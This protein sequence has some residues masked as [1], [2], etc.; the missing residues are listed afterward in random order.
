MPGKKN[1]ARAF[2][3]ATLVVLIFLSGSLHAQQTATVVG[4]VRD[5]SGAVVP[6]TT[7]S[8][9]NV[10][11]GLVRK[12]EADTQGNYVL[13]ALPIGRYTF[14]AS[15]KGFKPTQVPNVTL[16]VAQEARIDV[17][18]EPGDVSSSVTVSDAPSLLV[19]DSSSIGQV[20]ENKKIIDLPLNGRD[21]T[22]LASLT[23]GA[24]TSNIATGSSGEQHGF[25]TVQVSGGQSSKTEFLLDGITDQEQLYDG[26]QFS[27]SIDFLQEFRVQ[28]NAFSAEFGRGSAVI[29]VSTKGGTN[30]YHGTI[31]E[32]LRND[33]LD[34][35]NFFALSNPPLRRNQFG[36]S[37]GGPIVHN[38]LFF[39]LNY[40]GTQLREPTTRNTTVPLAALRNGDLSVLSKTVIDPITQSPF[41]GNVIPSNRID[42]TSA[43]FLN[44]IP[45]PNTANGTYIWNASTAQ[46][47]NQGNARV[48]YQLSPN[49]SLFARYSINDA[50]NTNPGSLPV[51]G[52]TAQ[53][54][55]VQN[56]VIS[57]T[58]LFNP[59]LLNEARIG[60]A[61]LYYI[62]APQ[63]LGTNYTV[64]SGILGFTEESQNFP[65]FPNLSVS[66]YGALVNGVPFAPIRNPTNTWQYNDILT[67]TAGRHT[68]KMG[69][70]FR[71][72]HLTSTNAAYSRGSFSYNGSFSGNSFVDYLLGFPSSGT[73]DFPRNHFGLRDANY[74]LFIQDDFKVTSRLTLNLGLRYE[75]DA[76][77][78][79]DLGQ[80]SYFDMTR[81]KWIVSTYHGSINLTT[82]QVAAY[83]YDKYGA[84]MITTKEAGIDNNI[85][86]ISHKQFAPRIGL[87]YR[88][89]DNDRT[90]VRAAY[91]IFYLLQRG[92]Q[93]VSN[94]IINLPFILDEGKNAPRSA[95]GQPM[96]NTA[97][98]FNAPLG[99]GGPYLSQIDLFIR[100]PYMQQWNF[101]IQHRF[102]GNIALEAAYVGNK[103]TRLERDIPFNY[104]VPGPGAVNSRRVYPQFSGGDSYTNSG[105][106]NYNALQVKLEKRYSAGLSLLAAYTYSKLIDSSNLDSNNGV[107][108]PRNLALD[109]GVAQYDITQRLVTSYTYEL[110]F[111]RGKHFLGGAGGFTNVLVG[112][113]SLGGILTFQSGFPFSPSMNADPTNTGNAYD[114]RPNRIA[115]GRID[116]WTVQRYFDVSAFTIPGLYQIGTAGRNI[117]R[118]PG[119]ANWDFSVLKT[120]HITERISHELRFEAFNVTN[121]PQFLNPDANIESATAG[122]ILSARPARILQVAMKLYF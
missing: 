43:F 99:D 37:V 74:H 122:Q 104:P 42:P 106:S 69:I 57:F 85:Q 100:P 59:R 39:F 41:P 13:S 81:G 98:F 56:S 117:L 78:S 112:G 111:G 21:F 50:Q 27:P 71:R 25:S 68:I 1:T 62:K 28:A 9:Q 32:F 10:D 49:N 22:Q 46:Q 105:S 79:Q 35:R 94:G 55:R 12:T 83:A 101:A 119:L 52:G 58:H 87:A 88:P 2:S 3:L 30:D 108:D 95:S 114:G 44:Y 96:L 120:T 82:Q 38:K 73:R 70:D 115:S 11:T 64:Q 61:H 5:A 15:F 23:P 7:I 72:F 33:K 16:Q 103:G 84:Y 40:D 47:V 110:P 90:V 91:G 19:T 97:N 17:R 53:S 63:G 34:A 60:Y 80:N 8:A 18:L 31:F 75:L 54:I 86:T 4:S 20:I 51:S 113:W 6:G 89:F 116:D 76:A 118:G 24:I 14:T 26:V 107:Q 102:P 45:A 48:D 93:S 65:G 109:R 67:Y 77:P 121:T 36:G 29:N 66:G 92:N